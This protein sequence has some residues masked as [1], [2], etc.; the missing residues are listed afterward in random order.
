MKSKKC[1]FLILFLITISYL[2]PWFYNF[3]SKCLN[4]NKFNNFE[5]VLHNSAQSYENSYKYEW[6]ITW[7]EVDD[8]RGR[9]VIID[10]NNNVY[11]SGYSRFSGQYDAFLVKYNELGVQQWNVTWGGSN[12]ENQLGIALDSLNNIYITGETFSYGN[13][14][15]DIFL[16]KYNE[17]GIQQWNRTWGYVDWERGHD[18]VIDSSDNIYVVGY[19][20]IDHS[21]GAS[22]FSGVLI[23][24]DSSGIEIW[25]VTWDDEKYGLVDSSFWCV[26]L[27][28]EENILCVG[29]T[30]IYGNVNDIIIVKFNKTGEDLWYTQYDYW[31]NDVGYGVIT[32]S[33]NNI[34]ITG[35]SGHSP[36]LGDTDASL[37][38]FNS[39][40]YHQWTAIWDGSGYEYAYDLQLD[41]YEFIYIV[42]YTSSFGAGGGDMFVAKYNNLGIQ[43]WNT[44]W[45]ALDYDGGFDIYFD[46]F[47][48]M[49]VLG[50]T[51]NYGAGDRDACLVKY[52]NLAPGLKINSP[53]S[54]VCTQIEPT[55]NITVKG[56]NIDRV[57]Y[58]TNG[59]QNKYEISTSN[60]TFFDT[61]ES[62]IW[63]QLQYG[64]VVLTFWVNNTDGY[65]AYRNVTIWKTGY[66]QIYNNLP[67]FTVNNGTT[68]YTL[69]WHLID[70]DGNTDI[71]W[72]ERN[73]TKIFEGTWTN[74]SNILFIENETLKAADYNYTC[75]VI[76]SYGALNYSS[77]FVTILN[78]P[79]SLSNNQDDFAI[80]IG[81]TNFLLSWRA[82]DYDGN[83]QSYW[84]KRN[85]VN[86]AEG[87]WANDSDIIFIES[88][89][90]DLGTY[91]YTCFVNDTALAVNQSSIFVVVINES[92]II[93]NNVLNF[94]VNAGSTDFLLS[95]HAFDLDGNNHSY[96]IERNSF[97]VA[98]GT[99]Q[100]NTDILF[101]ENE[102]LYAGLYNYTCFVNDT[103]GL[104]SQSF[105]FVKVNVI[106]QYSGILL[107]SI[108]TYT[109]NKY[110]IFNCSWLDADG[111][112]NEVKIEFDHQNYTV[113]DS[114]NG[115]FTYS[116]YNL[117]ANEIGYQFRWHAMD[118]DGAWNST[119]WYF[120]ILSKQEVQL[121]ILFN[122]TQEN[123]IDSFNPIVNI[124]ILNLDLT[125]GTLQLFVNGE[126]KQQIES[127]SLTN[128]SQYL[129]GAY[130]ITAILA[131]Q[132]YTGYEMLWLNI[133]EISPPVI[134][135][136]FSE[137]QITPIIPEYY[138]NSLKINCTVV[139]SSPLN[140]VYL[141]E[142]S[143]GIFLNR[144]LTELENN[145][146][147]YE[148]DIS[149]LNWNDFF[150]FY[151]YANDTWGNIGIND[152]FSCFYRVYIA[153]YQ[154][155]ISSISYIPHDAPNMINSSTSFRITADDVGSGIYLIRYKINDS[156]W[157]SYSQPFNLSNY[158]KGLHELSYYSIDNAGNSEEVKTITILL[159]K[160]GESTPQGTIS[161]F[162]LEVL[163]LIVSITTIIILFKKRVQF[164]TSN[165]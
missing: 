61:V 5:N 46:S 54:N 18:V 53:S 42:G 151:F 156:D 96:W 97:R 79:P 88:E 4:L 146:W 58:T 41:Y 147:S 85:S 131:D 119:D 163:I 15:S 32:D 44:T 55:F 100:N 106:P 110:Y 35:H 86:I 139:D 148:L 109:P 25:N 11:I 45:G 82:I 155:P 63:N 140:W 93:I 144:S 17:Q 154:S 57:W 143:T 134:S 165:R 29:D 76:D 68:G 105:I 22:D 102:I 99:W 38:K 36:D 64:K 129:N 60:G 67:D 113:F 114:F 28:S 157:F 118:D 137:N 159:V 74:D 117:P 6:N 92:P 3:N 51:A 21:P 90:L 39:S 26:T 2:F 150:Y 70:A 126:L 145:E 91:N 162:N 47:D 158:N 80:H 128:V 87:T 123:L 16:V 104:M 71:Y 48:N 138:H 7:G 40:G 9:E 50:N 72:I 115:D 160:T 12:T 141:C 14:G 127:Y 108:N 75:F 52:K 112:I 77:I 142:N 65:G 37:I 83:N 153:D 130:N 34:Y 161:S 98:E 10:T 1:S 33:A 56:S 24:Y 43:L 111:I 133:Q 30:S 121:V 20:D 13:G 31:L 73:S 27:D 152:N 84:I 69:S 78:I 19:T 94:S 132:N 124:T 116:F 8:D 66:P 49:F 62:S 89:I 95:W 135:F 23:K 101:V 120:F 125:P 122:G 103:F 59:E 107:P 164:K 136:T 149:H 81:S